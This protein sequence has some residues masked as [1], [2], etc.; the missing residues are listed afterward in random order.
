[1]IPL[2]MVPRTRKMMNRN[3]NQK[4]DEQEREQVQ[5]GL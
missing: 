3:Q 1:M 4:N 5:D 2:K